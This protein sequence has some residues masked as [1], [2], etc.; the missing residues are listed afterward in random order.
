M[1]LRY[2][3]A[4]WRTASIANAPDPSAGSQIVSS[5]ICSGVVRWP[6]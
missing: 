4:S 2:S 1:R 3:A 5:R 6:S